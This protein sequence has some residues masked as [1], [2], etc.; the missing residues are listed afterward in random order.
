[1]RDADADRPGIVQP[2]DPT[3]EWFARLTEAEMQRR[4]VFS[5][6]V[7]RGADD[8]MGKHPKKTFENFAEA[9]GV[10]RPTLYRWLARSWRKDPER[11]RV[12]R[13]SIGI[14]AP[15]ELAHQ[16]LGWQPTNASPP[17]PASE[18]KQLPPLRDP[19]SEAVDA[20]LADPDVPDDEKANIRSIIAYL[21]ERRST[22]D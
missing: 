5:R 13:F 18:G 4:R 20:V 17:P 8:W 16:L 7:R 11:G 15:T 2:G 9:I 14:G 12:D 10:S 21:T 22:K 6:F 3:D 19:A 1:M